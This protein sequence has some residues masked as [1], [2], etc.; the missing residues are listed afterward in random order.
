MKNRITL[1]LILLFFL[2]NF[3]NAQVNFIRQQNVPVQVN[4][5]TLLKPWAGGLSYPMFS[6]FDFDMDGTTDL[7]CFDRA[8]NRIVPF[9]NGGTPNQVD[10]TYAPEYVKYFP[11]PRLWAFTY[12]FDCD[13]KKDFITL[14]DTYNGI[15]AYKNISSTPGSL[16][17][18]LFSDKLMSQYPTT[19]TNMFASYGLVPAMSDVDNDGDVD[20]LCWN[21]GMGG[22]V[23]YNKNLSVENGFG[24]DSLQFDFI[25]SCW[26]NF[27]LNTNANR[28]NLGISCRI[29]FYPEDQIGRAHV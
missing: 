18:V 28:A 22:M 26:G 4:S 14:S 13:G 1:L 2:C 21:N 27:V 7:F 8:N 29:G 11:E 24:C 23:E 12:D 20:I 16:Q 19:Y 15:K 17:F 3:S 9:I 6:E 5:V 10:Y 25:T